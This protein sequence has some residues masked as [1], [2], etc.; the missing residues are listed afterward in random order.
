MI[1]FRE[2]SYIKVVVSGLLLYN[3]QQDGGSGDFVSVGLR[4]GRP[5]FRFDVGSGPAIIKSP[6]PLQMGVWH[7]LKLARYVTLGGFPSLHRLSITNKTID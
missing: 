2:V 6:K 4:G 5:E 7:H 1:N 3:G